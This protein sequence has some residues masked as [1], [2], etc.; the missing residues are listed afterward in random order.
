MT[1][2]LD[3]SA[4]SPQACFTDRNALRCNPLHLEDPTAL[5]AE[6]TK[7]MRERRSVRGLR[8]LRLSVPM[9]VPDVPR[10]TVSTVGD[11]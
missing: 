8:E 9:H 1:P 4:A 6:R 5:P 11:R 10:V 3:K 7:A 2:Q